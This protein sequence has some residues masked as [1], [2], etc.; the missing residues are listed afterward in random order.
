MIF[1]DAAIKKQPRVL[2]RVVGPGLGGDLG[3]MLLQLCRPWVRKMRYTWYVTFEVHKGG[4]SLK[5]R[6]PRSTRIFETEKEA[7]EF[8]RAKLDQGL[9]VYAG[10]LNPHLPR[11]TIPSNDVLCWL[12]EQWEEDRTDAS[13]L[14]RKEP[15]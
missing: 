15:G 4:T 2:E 13:G 7:K 14:D 5:R 10:T 12:A 1:K 3:L 9:I 6:S 11:R 8:A